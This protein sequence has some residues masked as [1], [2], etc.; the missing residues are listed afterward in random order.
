MSTLSDLT[1]TGRT[2]VLPG[3]EISPF[4]LSAFAEV[5]MELG[6]RHLATAALAAARLPEKEAAETRRVADA[7][8]QA[9]AFQFGKQVYDAAVQQTLMT[10]FLTWVSIKIKMPGVKRQEI[11]NLI[12][13]ENVWTVRKPVLE[14]MGYRFKDPNAQTPPPKAG[15]VGETLNGEKSPT[16]S[17]INADSTGA[18]SAA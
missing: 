1:S 3:Y 14:A 11:E 12:T 18:R 10:P 8:V 4:N 2:D 5:E 15:A 16:S 13:P 6:A 9:G 17:E 7:T